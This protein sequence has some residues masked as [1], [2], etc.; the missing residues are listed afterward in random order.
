MRMI[1]RIVIVALA[2]DVGPGV[3][4]PVD[5]VIDA[6]LPQIA[7]HRLIDLAPEPV[8]PFAVVFER[9]VFPVI[10]GEGLVALFHL[11]NQLDQVTGRLLEVRQL[12]AHQLGRE[13]IEKFCH[14]TA[15]RRLPV[16][17]RR[18]GLIDAAV[19]IPLILEMVG[20][21]RVADAGRVVEIPAR[22]GD[23]GDAAAVLAYVTDR[24]T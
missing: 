22:L 17:A 6:D 12:P 21:I 13:Q 18:P 20:V 9:V 5:R 3:N 19:G 10:R 2:V 16:R 1:V 7:D 23:A 14:A 4:L 8:R 15:T 24:K 11:A